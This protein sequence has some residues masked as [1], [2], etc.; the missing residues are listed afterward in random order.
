LTAFRTIVLVTAVIACHPIRKRGGAGGVTLA[1]LPAESD[2]YP[3]AARALTDSLNDAK[4][5]GIDRKELSK[6]SLEV[7][8]LSI[9]CVEPSPKC[10]AEVGKSLAANRLLFA[11]IAKSHRHHVQVT[12]TLF[13][14]DSLEPRTTQ[15]S[16]ASEQEATAGIKELVAEA[17]R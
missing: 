12:V 7:V 2:D 8:Q 13:D 3:R 17:T 5:G 16:F 6:V 9:E 1:V 10:Y 15:K 11:Q 14:V 4:I